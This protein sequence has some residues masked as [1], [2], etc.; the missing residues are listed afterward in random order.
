MPL[1]F[2]FKF[3]KFFSC[4]FVILKVSNSYSTSN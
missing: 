4:F 2:L 3:I 1:L